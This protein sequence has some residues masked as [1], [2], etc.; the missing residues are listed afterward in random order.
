VRCVDDEAPTFYDSSW[1]SVFISA[2]NTGS[3]ALAAGAYQAVA[4]VT[5]ED[6]D[7]VNAYLDGEAAEPG[8]R[9]HYTLRDARSLIGPGTHTIEAYLP[10]ELGGDEVIQTIM[11]AD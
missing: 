1:D 3:V 8:Q 9:F 11:I 4:R 7:V 2:V 6:H 10:A 5:K